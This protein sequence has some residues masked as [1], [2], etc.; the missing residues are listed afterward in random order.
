MTDLPNNSLAVNSPQPQVNQTIQSQLREQNEEDISLSVSQIVP[1]LR[2]RFWLI[3]SI[4][5]AVSLSAV[6]YAFTRAPVY[7]ESFQILVDTPGDSNRGLPGG[8][9][10]SLG[11]FLGVST[12]SDNYFLTQIQILYSYKIIAPVL[13]KLNKVFPPETEEEKV[14]YQAFIEN[15]LSIN[16][17]KDTNIIIVSYQDI[18][19]RKVTF[20]L[21]ELAKVYLDYSLNDPRM[22]KT[23]GLQFVEDQLPKLDQE[24]SSLQKELERFR[25]KH[26]FIDPQS[27]SRILSSNLTNII[28][29]KQENQSLLQE[30][31][32]RY[33]N[34]QQQLAMGEQEAI[35]LTA[36]SESPRYMNLLEKLREVDT[37]LA[38]EST[39]FT[40]D[41]PTIKK[42][43]QQRRNL[44]PLIEEEA[45][46]ILGNIP[47]TSL[48]DLTAL[49]S[50]NTIREDILS[51]LLK[52]E[53]QLEELRARQKE[54]IG[55]ENDIRQEIAQ[56]ARLTSEYVDLQRKIEIANQS[57][58]SY[59]VFQQ[60]L[61][62]ERAKTIYP[63]RLVSEIRTPE[64]PVS[65]PLKL[66]VL[67]TFM[68][69]VLGMGAG[70]LAEKLDDTFHNAEEL[71]Q[72]TRLPLL[73]TIPQLPR[74]LLQNKT[75]FPGSN[76]NFS[77]FL[78]AF[79][80]LQTNL[81]LLNPKQTI[82][83]LTISSAI[84]EEGKSTVA[85]HLAQAAA[86]M[87]QKVLLV[88]GDLRLPQLHHQPGLTSSNQYS[89]EDILNQDLAPDQAITISPLNPNLYVL[90]GTAK[91]PNPSASLS[92]EKFAT[93][94][95]QWQEK[96][97]LVIFD[98]PPL[99]GLVD[100]KLLT[101]KTDGLLLVV[102]LDKT[103]KD[104]VKKA[105]EEMQSA[106]LPILG[107]VANQAQP[108]TMKIN[109][110]NQRYLQQV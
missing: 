40:E 9:N 87:G 77:L 4:S 29:K 81:V 55:L 88:D 105:V 3:G 94:S 75:D 68:G 50:P 92:C 60:E 8:I 99:L 110:Y 64:E 62:L 76:P 16:R 33:R 67:G 80:G 26:N 72:E 17:P 90:V 32:I 63:W 13:E 25:K 14:E 38:E 46:A 7:E 10:S 66:S 42:L 30:Q 15:Q 91:S 2:R 86:K 65:G 59:L 103:N 98:A 21:N 51:S 101:A 5:L 73:A 74:K 19:P 31:E 1:W 109:R 45:Q 97:D 107:L 54:L 12:N 34:L 79:L 69:I 57:L 49:T 52:A 61:E 28:Q 102:R 44:V 53:T 70:L 96:F 18:D 48:T 35:D 11:N 108:Y 27:Q 82:K 24:V 58:T 95:R 43:R 78:E 93:L 84:P 56:L 71:K 22:K 39:R 83:S 20:I 36:L 47:Q 23:Q 85:A 6:S 104:L 89:L 106:Q 100:A 37:K 41:N